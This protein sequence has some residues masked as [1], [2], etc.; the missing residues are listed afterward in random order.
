MRFSFR[1]LRF[2]S[3]ADDF[4]G[5]RTI[6]AR[7]RRFRPRVRRRSQGKSMRFAAGAFA[8]VHAHQPRAFRQRPLFRIPAF[9]NV[10]ER[11]EGNAGRRKRNASRAFESHSF[12]RKEKQRRVRKSH[13]IVFAG[14]ARVGRENRRRSAGRRAGAG[15]GSHARRLRRGRFGQSRFR[16]ILFALCNAALANKGKSQGHGRRGKEKSFC[17]LRAKKAKPQAKA[18]AGAGTRFL[19]FRHSFQL[20]R[21]QGF[22]EAPH[23]F[24]RTPAFDHAIRVRRSKR[25]NRARRFIAIHAGNAEG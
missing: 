13:A 17:G 25:N 16:N 24:A 18:R 9:E 5:E 6:S 1:H 7:G 10:C 2:A 19:H 23:A 22:A 3:R 20:R 12:L 14:N 11:L 21:L 4:A 8:R 15:E